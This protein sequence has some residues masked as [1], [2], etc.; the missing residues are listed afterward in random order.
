M[1]LC[2][3]LFISSSLLLSLP[4]PVS[5]PVSISLSHPACLYFILPHSVSALPNSVSPC[6]S[7]TL[8]VSSPVSLPLSQSLSH[9][10]CLCFILPFSVSASPS[11]V[12]P[13]HSITL[14]VSPCLLP[15]RSVSFCTPQLRLGLIS[16]CF[17]LLYV[18]F[19]LLFHPSSHALWTVVL[20]VPAFIDLK[21]IFLYFEITFVFLPQDLARFG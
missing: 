3:P 20:W 4:H 16:S 2:H 21:L 9:L 18:L 10:T 8:S 13:C 15:S 5:L 11:S 1:Y 19:S 6:L 12:S 17:F 14:S 7:M